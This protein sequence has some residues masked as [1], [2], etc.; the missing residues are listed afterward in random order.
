MY[1]PQRPELVDLIS[2]QCSPMS[3]RRVLFSCSHPIWRNIFTCSTSM[4]FFQPEPHNIEHCHETNS[5]NRH[6]EVDVGEIVSIMARPATMRKSLSIP[7]ICITH[8]QSLL[9]LQS[10]S[11]TKC[12]NNNNNQHVDRDPEAA[13]NIALVTQTGGATIRSSL[14]TNVN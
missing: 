4:C 1:L 14:A 12:Y 6:T 13:T 7:Y 3:P 9:F 10:R 11:C 8:W 5:G 2:L